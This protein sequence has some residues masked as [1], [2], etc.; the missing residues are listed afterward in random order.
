MGKPCK[1]KITQIFVD[2]K[3]F[4]NSQQK[5]LEEKWKGHHYIGFSPPEIISF[6]GPEPKQN[7]CLL[8][9]LIPFIKFKNVYSSTPKINV[10]DEYI[11]IEEII[12]KLGLQRDEKVKEWLRKYK[13]TPEDP[14][15]V[16]VNFNPRTI[17][18]AGVVE[19]NVQAVSNAL[20]VCL[21]HV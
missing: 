5:F 20:I 21:S 19:R 10:I 1:P 16:L 4:K 2:F 6:V 12:V 3:F 13:S 9:P 17:G 11:P 14:V 7:L 15:L 8:K 18:R